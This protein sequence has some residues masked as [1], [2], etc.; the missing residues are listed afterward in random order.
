MNNVESSNAPAANV[1]LF[2]V[3][4]VHTELKHDRRFPK[5]WRNLALEKLSSEYLFLVQV[6]PTFDP[7]S[8]HP[9]ILPM[10]FANYPAFS[11]H[12]SPFP[13]DQLFPVRS[14]KM[15]TSIVLNAKKRYTNQFECPNCQ[16]RPMY[17]G[18]C[19]QCM[20]SGTQQGPERRTR[21]G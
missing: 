8:A 11:T 2:V 6:A 1:P 19:M 15:S 4:I 21:H 14:C 17:S 20:H 18:R 13:G 9:K 12:L 3:G 5:D 16:A 10:T 7:A